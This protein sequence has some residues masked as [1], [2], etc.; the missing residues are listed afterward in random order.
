MPHPPPLGQLSFHT[1]SRW[2][3]YATPTPAGPAMPHPPPLGQPCVSS[4]IF[5]RLALN[6][7]CY[8]L[9]KGITIMC[10]IYIVLFVFI[11]STANYSTFSSHWLPLSWYYPRRTFFFYFNGFFHNFSRLSWWE[12][13][14]TSV[15]YPP[16][17]Q[18]PDSGL[19]GGETSLPPRLPLST[20]PILSKRTVFL[21]VRAQYKTTGKSVPV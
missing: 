14:G 15:S 6:F 20:I 8:Y 5:L 1:H 21:V 9:L 10:S 7:N 4:A 18:P 2:A 12:F 11:I 16:P 19:P 13:C 17:P 3:S